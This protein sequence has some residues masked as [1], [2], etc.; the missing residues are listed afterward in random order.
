MGVSIVPGLT[1]TKRTPWGLWSVVRQRI[2]A[3]R[4]AFVAQ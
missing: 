4:P 2:R 3:T 1:P